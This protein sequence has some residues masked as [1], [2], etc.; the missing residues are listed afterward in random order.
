[1]STRVESEYFNPLS[2][3][4]EQAEQEDEVRRRNRRRRMA[5]PR[6]R[7]RFNF[8]MPN[9]RF[10]SP[11]FFSR[12]FVRPFPR[13]RPRR[14]PR[15]PF[16]FPRPFPPAYP[17]PFPP[18]VE[19]PQPPV[20]QGGGGGGGM[21]APPPSYSEPAGDA[22][23]PPTEPQGA[24]VEGTDQPSSNGNGEPAEPGDGDTAQAT[25][26]QQTGGDEEYFE[27]GRP[28]PSRGVPT[29]RAPIRRGPSRP[30]R[31]PVRGRPGVLRPGLGRKSPAGST[32]RTINL[33]E[34]VICGGT[35][36]A[37]LDNFVFGKFT[38]RKDA[39]RNHPAQIDAIASE[40]ISRAT[41]GRPVPTVCIVGHTDYIGRLD[42]NYELGLRRAR[43]VKDALCKKLGKYATNMTF[44]VNSL[45]ETDPSPSGTTSATRDLNR[46]VE[47]FLL[48][49]RLEG[50]RCGS[51]N[52]GGGHDSSVERCGVP[53]RG[54]HREWE[55]AQELQALRKTPAKTRPARRAPVRP[56]LSFFLDS[57]DTAERNH[58]HHQAQG[59][60]RRI[61]AIEKPNAAKCKPL[62][63]GPTPY[64]TGADIINAIR[65]AQE[66]TGKKIET[67]HIFG[68][69]NNTG[70][71]GNILGKAAGIRQNSLPVDSADGGR[72]ISDI[73]T[74][75]LSNNVIFVLHGCR[76]AEGC[77]V[78][79][80]DDNFAQSLYDHLKARLSNPRVYGHYNRGCAGR[81][82]SW[83]LYSKTHPKGKARLRPDYTDPGG[84][85]S[86]SRELEF[87]WG[88]L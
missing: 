81:D 87:Q 37:K 45:G 79:G 29:R 27:F 46:R 71:A 54:A 52:G 84:C 43:S 2:E 86:S 23:G 65:A 57:T 66:C 3:F 19:P 60:A 35:P 36:F 6:L 17:Y 24:P 40:I 58:F 21:S 12:R 72:H 4:F 22:W 85:R 77:N 41:K 75:V 9:R 80:D 38:L 73:P 50:E 15:P 26:A 56:K 25:D 48:S 14:R 62:R 31:G 61:G 78:A 20:S 64:G 55:M 11:R 68:H 53:A 13:P 39:I 88:S 69:S 82:N 70:I 1:M 59:T 5:G 10:L 30:V 18:P 7:R 16:S 8:A 76:Q 67:V 49:E 33:G 42:F 74:D 28:G 32:K 47:V 34:V 51:G 44:V 63:V 83:C